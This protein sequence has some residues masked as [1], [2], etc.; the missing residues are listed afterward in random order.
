MTES[1]EDLRLQIVALR[2]ALAETVSLLIQKKV[3]TKREAVSHFH[4]LG[5]LVMP[6]I[7][8]STAAQIFEE[9]AAYIV[10]IPLEE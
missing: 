9:I 6:Q 4:G 8:G 1:V 7:K 5:D 2:I 10:E 3:L